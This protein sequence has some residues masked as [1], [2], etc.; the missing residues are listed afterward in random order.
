MSGFA[1]AVIGGAEFLIRSAI[2]S[3][4]YVAGLA[5]WRIAKDGTA[6]PNNATVRGSVSAGS[7]TVLLNAGGIHVQNG[8]QQFDINAA[9]GFLA[10]LVPDNG[11]IVQV[12]PQAL[13]TRGQSPSPVGLAVNTSDIFNVYN[14]SGAAN[15]Q[16]YTGFN[17]GAYTGKSGPFMIGLSQA[18]NDAGTDDTSTLQFSAGLAIKLFALSILT[19]DFSLKDSN[20]HYYLAGENQLFNL[21]ILSTDASVT[22]AVVF[23]HTFTRAPFV[24]CNINDSAGATGK[25]TARAIN[26]TT[27]G[28]T[29]WVQ[30]P[31]GTAAGSAVTLKCTWMA[32]EYTP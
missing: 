26:I 10:R 2:K 20:G 32:T 28:F 18:A 21:G 30:S 7:G 27:T 15:E 9:A 17:M 6:E 12:S 8:A 25:W 1:N 31:T 29:F 3:A 22:I 14:N 13:S 4:N 5:G 16:V 11:T 24:V 19:N 23:T